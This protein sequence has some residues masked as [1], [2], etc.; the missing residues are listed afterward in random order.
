MQDDF[1]VSGVPQ[2]TGTGLQVVE[3]LAGTGASLGGR[4]RWVRC[5]TNLLLR[6]ERRPRQTSDQA[7]IVD[8]VSRTY[9]SSWASG[10]TR[11][12]SPI[13]KASRAANWRAVKKMSFANDGPTTS[14][15][16]L[17]PSNA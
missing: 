17:T 16:L 5:L 6:Q 10:T 15:S 4:Q 11:L 8:A 7:A 9:V 3:I 12:I 14:T 13:A 1:E 2:A